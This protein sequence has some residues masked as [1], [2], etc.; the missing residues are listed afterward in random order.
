M[1]TSPGQLILD[2]CGRLRK[3]M[4]EIPGNAPNFS[5]FNN[6]IVAVE[7]MAESGLEAADQALQ[8]LLRELAAAP[9]GMS[10]VILSAKRFGKYLRL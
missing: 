8:V 4:K 9:D 7:N 10:G 6:R 3:L 2:Q 1:A 5:R